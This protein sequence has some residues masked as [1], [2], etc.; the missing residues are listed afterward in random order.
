MTKWPPGPSLSH[1]VFS[2]LLSA[3]W[4]GLLAI[5][6]V[7]GAGCDCLACK[8][9]LTKGRRRLGMSEE[10]FPEGTITYHWDPVADGRF[11]SAR[12]GLVPPEMAPAVEGVQPQIPLLSAEF[13]QLVKR[14]ARPLL[15]D[16]RPFA[17]A[18]Y[19]KSWGCTGPDCCDYVVEVPLEMRRYHHR[20]EVTQGP[21]RHAYHRHDPKGT[22]P[23]PPTALH[24]FR[25]A[26]PITVALHH[27]V[28]D[29]KERVYNWWSKKKRSPMT[30]EADSRQ[31]MDT[32]FLNK[33]MS[34]T[35]PI[36]VLASLQ[37]VVEPSCLS[38]FI[39]TEDDPESRQN[40]QLL[41]RMF[42]KLHFTS[43]AAF[44]PSPAGTH[45]A[46]VAFDVLAHASVVIAGQSG[47]S[48]LS[49]MLTRG[50]AVVVDEAKSMGH[51]MDEVK[52]NIVRVQRRPLFWSTAG[53]PGMPMR[54]LLLQLEKA[55]K[56]GARQSGLRRRILAALQRQ[57]LEERHPEC[58]L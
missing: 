22:N 14:Q 47:F 41:R 3:G 10:D 55:R 40:L 25:D 34:V 58:F 17:S 11:Q 26:R 13:L 21:M 16:K 43:E 49:A 24:V 42:P 18:Y 2:T 51:S 52:G 56:L 48:R 38:M 7:F 1:F 27:R 31:V 44:P 28:G 46:R 36:F 19:P 39:L 54:H 6:V 53:L 32:K 37:K 5:T 45:P 33:M 29:V 30:H 57:G 15:L 20:F 12:I 4:V 9:K 50:T 35:W 8:E 23:P